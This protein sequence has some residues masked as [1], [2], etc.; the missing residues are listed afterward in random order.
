MLSERLTSFEKSPNI[1]W[2]QIQCFGLPAEAAKFHSSF[3]LLCCLAIEMWVV[4]YPS[5]SI[6]AHRRQEHVS[7]RTLAFSAEPSGETETGERSGP[8]TDTEDLLISSPGCGRTAGSCSTVAVGSG[9]RSRAHFTC[10]WVRISICSA[11]APHHAAVL[12]ALPLTVYMQSFQTPS[13][14]AVAC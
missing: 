10:G 11:S 3:T 14:G 5:P 8:P 4:C 6:A 2:L 7:R 13:L 1:W 9:V 12:P